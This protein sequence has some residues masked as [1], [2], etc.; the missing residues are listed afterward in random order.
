MPRSR[1]TRCSWHWVQGHAGHDM[2]ERADQLAREGVA[3][4]RAGALS[5][6]R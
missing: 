4:V 6:K 1:T 2:N 5:D 3:A